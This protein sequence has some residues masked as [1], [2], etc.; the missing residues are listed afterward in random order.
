M[1]GQV[2]PG[3]V[4]KERD[5]TNARIDNTIDNVGAF[6]GPFE[7]GPVNEIVNIT[8]EKELLETFGRPNEDNAGY[9]FTATNFLAYGGQLQV[10]RVG[11]ST[12]VNAVSDSATATLIEND[13]EYTV[14]HFDNAQASGTML[15]RLLVPMATTLLFTLLTTVSTLP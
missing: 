13:T 2:S 14:N 4:I 8:N 15:L 12:L 6:V 1:A 7:R 9:W 5:L 10:V 11:T 3:V